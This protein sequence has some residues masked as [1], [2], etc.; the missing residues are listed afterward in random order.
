MG[1]LIH[2]PDPPMP[3]TP[4][5]RHKGSLT[6]AVRE[7]RRFESAAAAD[8]RMCP[9]GA[10]VRAWLRVTSTFSR[11]YDRRRRPS[12]PRNPYG[13]ESGRAAPRAIRRLIRAQS[14][15]RRRNPQHDP[16][17]SLRS[18][19]RRPLT[20]LRPSAG[21]RPTTADSSTHTT[22]PERGGTWLMTLPRTHLV[23]SHRA[24]GSTAHCT[25]C[26]THCSR[27]LMPASSLLNNTAD[28]RPPAPHRHRHRSSSSALINM[29]G[30]RWRR[31]L[32]PRALNRLSAWLEK[33]RVGSEG[34]GGWEGEEGGG[35]DPTARC[36]PVLCDGA[37]C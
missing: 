25:H 5:G 18:N 11:R 8:A 30:Q 34:V 31:Q 32:F 23:S 10:C 35:R 20:G 27:P 21:Q 24:P 33:Y 37:G 22:H 17:D 7:E 4:V 19:G 6:F 16:M 14:A 1:R 29:Q 26:T 12:D 9:H 2:L 28:N 36:S 3:P 13:A 15:L